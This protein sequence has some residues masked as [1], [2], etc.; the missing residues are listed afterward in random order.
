MTTGERERPLYPMPAVLFLIIVSAVDLIAISQISF[1]GVW[2]DFPPPSP[3]SNPYYAWSAVNFYGS[4]VAPAV[5]WA[6]LR[7]HSLWRLSIAAIPIVS[8]A[9]FSVFTELEAAKVAS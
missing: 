4:F 5:A 2:S 8:H 6:P 9:A 7:V 3:W 1:W